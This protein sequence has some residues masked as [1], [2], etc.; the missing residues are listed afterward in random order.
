MSRILQTFKETIRNPYS[1]PGGY[2]IALYFL[3]GERVCTKCARDE[4]KL[5]CDDTINGWGQWQAGYAGVYWEGPP[6]DC[7]HCYD[8]QDSEY[9][10]PDEVSDAQV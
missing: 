2:T 8:P 1:F 9:G 7:V 5:I 4:W 10:D 6:Q 3:D